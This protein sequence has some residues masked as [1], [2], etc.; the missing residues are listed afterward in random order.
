MTLATLACSH[1]NGGSMKKPVHLGIWV[2]CAVL[3]FGAA[4][5]G[6]LA[7]GFPSRPIHMLVGYDAGGAADVTARVVAQRLG[8]PLGQPIVIENRPGGGGSI[9]NQKTA[10]SPA[11]GYTVVMMT[12]S[13][14]L[15][16]V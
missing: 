15:Q 5:A 13:S 1:P 16:S 9:A 14:T 3:V 6:A 2:A 12:S 4:S 8:D 7:Q 11:D 10:T